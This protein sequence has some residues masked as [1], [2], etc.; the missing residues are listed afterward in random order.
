MALRIGDASD[1]VRISS[2]SYCRFQILLPKKAAA[3][4]EVGYIGVYAKQVL[5]LL[6][7]LKRFPTGSPSK[8]DFRSVTDAIALEYDLRESQH[9]LHASRS[10]LEANTGKNKQ[11]NPGAI[12]IHWANNSSGESFDGFESET[13]IWDGKATGKPVTTGVYYVTTKWNGG[14][15]GD[16]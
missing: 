14:R 4:H 12:C 8:A 10:S 16:L 2:S 15:P 1:I 6:K 7:I 3:V 11:A 13:E 9:L 5:T